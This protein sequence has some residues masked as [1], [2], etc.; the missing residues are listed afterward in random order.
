GDASKASRDR[1]IGPRCTEIGVIRCVEKL[2]PELHRHPLADL[3]VLQ[4]ADVENDVAGSEQ[5]V[6]GAISERKR[7]G[8][9]IGGSVKPAKLGALRTGERSVAQRVR[10]AA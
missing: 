5:K 6:A 8:S 1:D 3:G 10:T 7:R 2:R 9:D 4:H